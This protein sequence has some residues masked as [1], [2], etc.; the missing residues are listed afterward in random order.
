MS[1]PASPPTGMAQSSMMQ[2]SSSPPQSDYAA[3]LQKYHSD[4]RERLLEAVWSSP[5]PPPKNRH[6]FVFSENEKEQQS[7]FTQQLE[8][9]NQD[10]ELRLSENIVNPATNKLYTPASSSGSRR[11]RSLR[12]S[13]ELIDDYHPVKSIAHSGGRLGSRNRRDTHFVRG[14]GMKEQPSTDD[15]VAYRS[16]ARQARSRSRDA[17][18]ILSSRSMEDV[19]S[20]DGKRVSTWSTDSS[21]P[22]LSARR[23]SGSGNED[24][25]SSSSEDEQ[26]VSGGTLRGRR[27]A[28]PPSGAPRVTITATSPSPAPRRT[29]TGPTMSTAPTSLPLQLPSFG[30]Q[31]LRVFPKA[32][33]VKSPHPVPSHE[34]VVNPETG[35]VQ[36]RHTPRGAKVQAL[37]FGLT[38][39]K[40]ASNATL[41]SRQ[42]LADNRQGQ[43]ISN[44]SLSMA[45]VSVK[46]SP[47]EQGSAAATPASEESFSAIAPSPLF[48][49][50]VNPLLRGRTTPVEDTE[51][52]L[53]WDTNNSR[54]AAAGRK[55]FR[56]NTSSLSNSRWD[57]TQDKEVPW[58]EDVALDE[59]ETPGFIDGL[60]EDYRSAVP[61]TP[62]SLPPPG[63]SR[64]S[65]FID[66]HGRRFG[67]PVPG[68]KAH[69]MGVPKSLGS[70]D[71][72]GSDKEN[73][74]GP[75]DVKTTSRGNH[76]SATRA[77]TRF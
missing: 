64:E 31:A 49:P 63:L 32:S 55:P 39:L 15:T 12:V 72:I 62:S 2:A 75:I 18:P 73:H 3:A 38:S 14:R 51:N 13:A 53:F 50:S 24:G 5:S 46:G 20:A 45:A 30:G 59:G 52:T 48:T 11:G 36:A 33:S 77:S 6:A 56:R 23:S 70:E 43:K 67:V 37:G 1:S 60:L 28:T 65:S 47:S 68:D 74:L 57:V 44:L 61:P 9:Q 8:Q 29:L 22:S 42:P 25:S 41:S 4:L 40:P 16:P 34:T 69:K 21:E 35:Q 10:D 19:A 54:A 17:K 27:P 71:L 58:D 7:L 66:R 76:S 26:D